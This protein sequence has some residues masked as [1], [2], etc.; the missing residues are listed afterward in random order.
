MLPAQCLADDAHWDCCHLIDSG[1][2]KA[3]IQRRD[4]EK[5]VNYETINFFFH[6]GVMYVCVDVTYPVRTKLLQ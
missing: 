4:E 6:I 1:A 3:H 2:I 5:Q